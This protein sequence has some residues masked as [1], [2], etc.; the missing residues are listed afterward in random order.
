MDEELRQITAIYDMAVEFFVT[1][2]FQLLGA[3]III[4]IGFWVGGRVASLITKLA[5][6]KNM[7]VTLTRFFAS[8]AKILVVAIMAIIALGKIGISIGPFVAALGAV[9]LGAGLALQSPLSNYGAG[10]NLILTRPFVVGDTISVQ[11][12]TGIV[13]EIRLAYTILT[14]EDGV[15]ITIPNKHIIG[16]IIHNSNA[17]TLI[18]IEVGI[19]YN[20]DPD[21]AIGAIKQALDRLNIDSDRQSPEVGIDTFGDS[22][23]NLAIRLWAPT[24]SHYQIRY[25]ANSAIFSALKTAQIEI[26]YPQREVR[27]LETTNAS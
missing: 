27:M 15:K 9:S 11:S 18:E 2:S 23:I 22:N 16:E 4:I 13:E 12:V 6:R 7:D 25:R 1:Y 14:N 8:T 10:L 20:A 24:D 3:V 5:E 19:A 17:D 26:A 21:M